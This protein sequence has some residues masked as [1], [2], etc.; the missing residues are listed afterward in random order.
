MCV[1]GNFFSTP[2]SSAPGVASRLQ[3]HVRRLN[4]GTK[5]WRTRRTFRRRFLTAGNCTRSSVQV[6]RTADRVSS[7]ARQLQD[8]AILCTLRAVHLY[9]MYFAAQC[10]RICLAASFGQIVGQ[11]GCAL[12]KERRPEPWFRSLLAWHVLVTDP[13]SGCWCSKTL[14]VASEKLRYVGIQQA[15][16]SAGRRGSFGNSVSCGRAVRLAYAFDASTDASV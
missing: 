7:T 1:L 13:Q 16:S 4:V 5:L 6:V 12:R 2:F 14:T 8:T 3:A 10:V 11:S 9:E 15:H